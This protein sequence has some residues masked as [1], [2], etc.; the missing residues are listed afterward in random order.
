MSL[1]KVFEENL[2]RKHYLKV[3]EENLLRKHYLKVFEENFLRKQELR[4]IFDAIY[5]AFNEHFLGQ[6]GANHQLLPF[7][8]QLPFR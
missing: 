5:Y 7:N 8:L 2:R 1:L 3:F 4:R 6:N